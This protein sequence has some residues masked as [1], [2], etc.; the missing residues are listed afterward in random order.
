MHTCTKI[1]V[2][3]SFVQKLETKTS[4]LYKMK[5]FSFLVCVEAVELKKTKIMNRMSEPDFK[6]AQG[7]I[8]VIGIYGADGTA[9]D[10]ENIERRFKKLKFCIYT[11]R[12]PTAAEIIILI[13]AAAKCDY[14]YRYRYVAF[15]YAGHGGSDEFGELFI[16]PQQAVN[17]NPGVEVLYIEKYIVEPLNC[18]KDRDLTRLFFFDCCQSQGKATHTMYSPRDSG[19][20]VKKTKQ[21]PGVLI[22]YATSDGQK[23]FG[24]QTNGGIWTYHLCKNLKKDL[25]LVTILAETYDEIVKKRESFQEP[26]TVTRIGALQLAQPEQKTCLLL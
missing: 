25:P 10:V 5:D 7:I 12:D 1:E 2:H 24:D 6:K 26:T 15:Y 21:H 17:S 14:P 3:I 8:F 16:T 13:K 23:S 18:L 9:K 11:E 19:Q 20:V 22:A 4:V